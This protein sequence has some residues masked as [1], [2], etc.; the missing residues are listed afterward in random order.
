[1]VFVCYPPSQVVTSSG[2][3][4]QD[5]VGNDEDWDDDDWDE[6]STPVRTIKI[7]SF[8][9]LFDFLFIHSLVR[10]AVGSSQ[11]EDIDSRNF[12]EILLPGVL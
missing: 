5:S 12:P 9:C 3:P 11:I 4:H 8:V 2:L 6:H 7:L 1:M 10:S